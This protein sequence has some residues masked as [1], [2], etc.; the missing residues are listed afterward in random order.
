MSD[1]YTPDNAG[2]HKQ[3]SMDQ[4]LN[5]DNRRD[6]KGNFSRVNA[7]FFIIAISHKRLLQSTPGEL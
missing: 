4:T 1:K 3:L 2:D 6:L 5:K 7:Y